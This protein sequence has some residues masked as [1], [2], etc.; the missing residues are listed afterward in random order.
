MSSD[1]SASKAFDI[2]EVLETI[3]QDL[4]LS[5]LLLAQRVSRA[6]KGMI[7]C[8]PK[9]QKALFFR[10]AIEEPLYFINKGFSYKDCGSGR[11]CSESQHEP[12]SQS[13]QEASHW[14]TQEDGAGRSI[15]VIINPFVSHKLPFLLKHRMKYWVSSDMSAQA[16]ASKGLL[17]KEASWRK[18]LFTQP[19]VRTLLYAL[20]SPCNHWHLV[21]MDEGTKGVTLEDMYSSCEAFVGEGWDIAAHGQF[22]LTEPVSPGEPSTWT[23]EE[24]SN[25]VHLVVEPDGDSTQSDDSEAEVS[26]AI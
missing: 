18:M 26:T 25:A 5:D 21:S 16:K 2:P 6:W 20:N 8:S 22:F 10:L 19:P 4:P 12:V 9:L 3:L 7:T 24:V 23:A 1:A 13:G 11:V 17:D 14:N 15:R